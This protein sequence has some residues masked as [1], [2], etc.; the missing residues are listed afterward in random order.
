MANET[1]RQ[2]ADRFRRLAE[3]L[4]DAPALLA[5]TALDLVREGFEESREPDGFPWSEITHR[6]GKPLIDTA[7]LQNS[8][9]VTHIGRHTFGIAAGVNYAHYHQLGTHNADGSQRIVP[10]KM[11]PDDGAPM[12]RAWEQ[13]FDADLQSLLEGALK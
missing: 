8:W 13:A 5:E 12:P 6:Q 3:A 2:A 11:V 10:R 9:H 4:R 1:A 7:T